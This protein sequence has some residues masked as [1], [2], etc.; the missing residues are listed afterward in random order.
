MKFGPRGC[1]KS[2]VTLACRTLGVCLTTAVA[3]GPLGNRGRCFDGD[4]KTTRRTPTCPLMYWYGVEPLVAVDPERALKLAANAKIPLV[5]RYVARR[6]VDDAL[7]KKDKGDLAAWATV[8]GS[9]NETERKDL[10]LGA[11]DGLRGR[12]AYPMPANWPTASAGLT[13]SM[14]ARRFAKAATSLALTFG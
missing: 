10:L 4:V 3:E 9:G 7:S 6:V 13:R 2:P 14:D 8:L 1:S 5:R 11:R 12:K